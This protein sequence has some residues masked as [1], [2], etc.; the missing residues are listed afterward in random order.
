MIILRRQQANTI[1]S[2]LR[3]TPLKNHRGGRRTSLA[4][5]SEVFS[6]SERQEV[7]FVRALRSLPSLYQSSL[8]IYEI[9]EEKVLTV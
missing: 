4:R 5:D 8:A 6:S 2:I 7:S 9:D 3:L 1:S